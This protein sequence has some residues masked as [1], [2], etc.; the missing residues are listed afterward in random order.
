[1]RT[2]WM[3]HT[4]TCLTLLGV[5]CASAPA[6]A[7]D[8]PKVVAS[9]DQSAT[10][11][12]P[13]VLPELKRPLLATPLALTVPTDRVALI[14]GYPTCL[15]RPWVVSVVDLGTRSV[16]WRSLSSTS[17]LGFYMPSPTGEACYKGPCPTFTVEMPPPSMSLLGGS[18][19][20]MGGTGKGLY[21]LPSG[22]AC[23]EPPYMLDGDLLDFAYRLVA[24]RNEAQ[25]A[26]SARV[27]TLP[28]R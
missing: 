26:I 15:V 2:P 25:A 24:A 4:A 11:S 12:T 8:K 6:P 14:W 9:S 23:P 19:T 10:T 21:A 7:P 3:K 16:T 20:M 18:G 17:E 5:A 28:G 22:T 13:I 1:M 27:S